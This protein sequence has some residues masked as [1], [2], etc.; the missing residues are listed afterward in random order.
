VLGGVVV[1]AGIGL[2]AADRPLPALEDGDERALGD[3]AGQA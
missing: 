3:A 2:V 1:V